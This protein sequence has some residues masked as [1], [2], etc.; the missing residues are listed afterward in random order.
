MLD[1]SDVAEIAPYLLVQPIS[2][3]SDTRE[4]LKTVLEQM[5]HA[6]FLSLV[7]S[8]F[9]PLMAMLKEIREFITSIGYGIE[10]THAVIVGGPE[11]K[12]IL[13]ESISHWEISPEKR[14]KGNLAAL[15]E[16]R[17]SNYI[18]IMLNDLPSLTKYESRE[19]ELG[20]VP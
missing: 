6:E 15:A 3:A 5:S 12:L 1:D 8:S 2:Y 7:A 20:L 9:A 16:R 19:N 4:S 10:G 18:H 17:I 13:P 11:G 14:S